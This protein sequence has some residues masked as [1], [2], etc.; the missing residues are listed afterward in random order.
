LQKKY[1]WDGWEGTVKPKKTSTFFVA[2]FGAFIGA[3][4]MI[5]VYQYILQGTAWENHRSDIVGNQHTTGP[6]ASEHVRPP[7]GLSSPTPTLAGV[8]VSDVVAR[9][10]DGIVGVINLSSAEDFWSRTGTAVIQGSGSGIIFK[11][12]G[13]ALWIATNHH[14]IEGAQAVDILLADGERMRAHILGSDRL[15]DLAVLS[16]PKPDGHRYTVLRFGN[17]DALKPGDATIAIGN[18]LGLDY[19]RTVTAGV[20]SA[21]NRSIPQDVSGEGEIDWELD[22]LQTDAAINPGNSGGALINMAGEVIGVASAKISEV[23]VEGI[24][25]A[26]PSNTAYPVLE[27]LA[28]TG[29]IERAYM[30]L[31][32]KDLTAF[33]SEHKDGTFL[34]PT[35]V[36]T[37]VVVIGIESG[38][39][40]A[41]AGLQEMD[42]IVQLD[43]AVVPTSAALRKYLYAHKQP[44]DMVRVTFYRD[45]RK[46]ERLVKL[47]KMP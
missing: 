38:G 19:L 21:T 15:S 39:P 12:T 27:K 34:L 22:V 30:G 26:I 46:E 23:G 33:A 44:G 16:I 9:V 47:G 8:S 45:G 28:Q 14:V 29:R 2:L 41:R 37:G 35:N 32:P 36:D 43:D 5:F 18:P 11:D 13:N 4:L 40:A 25:F 17:S 42:V 6:S 10:A 24:G 7:D 1:R 31:T 20:I 3:G